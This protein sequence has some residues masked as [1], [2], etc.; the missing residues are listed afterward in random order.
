MADDGLLSSF[1]YLF[2][3][4]LGEEDDDAAISP[5]GIA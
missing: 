5:R 2:A 3:D 1:R 4:F